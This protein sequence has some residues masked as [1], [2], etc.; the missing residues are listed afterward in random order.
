[1]KKLSDIY[2]RLGRNLDL[3]EITPKK[4]GTIT[5]VNGNCEEA[6]VPRVVCLQYLKTA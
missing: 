1:M 3:A 2:D 5:P 4:E 6:E